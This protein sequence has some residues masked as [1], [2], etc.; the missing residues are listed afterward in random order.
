MSISF[1]RV[2]I[3]GGGH[4][5]SV[6]E[7]MHTVHEGSTVTI[8]GPATIV[9]DRCIGQVFNKGQHFFSSMTMG[10]I[11]HASVSDVQCRGLAAEFLSCNGLIGNRAIARLAD[12]ISNF[13]LD[14]HYHLISLSKLQG[15]KSN[16]IVVSSSL[17]YLK[18]AISGAVLHNIVSDGS[19]L[20]EALH[21]R[22]GDDDG[23]AITKSNRH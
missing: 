11:N 4:S 15:I 20:F 13:F 6:N 23:V 19:I 12:S 14:V 2:R 7:D 9:G 21:Y 8:Q 18:A 16:G 17:C 5:G 22:P 10:A 1:S 3:S